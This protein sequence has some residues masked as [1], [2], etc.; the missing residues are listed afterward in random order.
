MKS[1]DFTFGFND[2]DY[3]TDDP[4]TYQRTCIGMMICPHCG[5]GEICGNIQ[6]NEQTTHGD[7]DN[8]IPRGNNSGTGNNGNDNR[9]RFSR[10]NGARKNT[11]FPM[12]STDKATTD[13]QPGRIVG[14]RVEDDKYRN[15]QQLVALKVQFK[16]QMYLYNLRTNNPV[17]DTLAEAWGDDEQGWIGKDVVIFNEE[18]DF[19][20]K[21]WLRL[22][23]AEE[24]ND[25]PTTTT[26]TKRA[27]K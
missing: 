20:G 7:D 15:G 10:S 2:P 3:A 27:K 18:D 8:M 26:T 11:G 5:R 13:Q 4:P 1:T 6:T 19:N 9:Q 14:A 12:L 25:E 24:K 22:E 16:S 23:P 21:L 17:L